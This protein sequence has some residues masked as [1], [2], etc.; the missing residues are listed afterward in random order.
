[1]YQS[2]DIWSFYWPMATTSYK[3]QNVRDITERERCI[4]RQRCGHMMATTPDHD[5]G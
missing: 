3:I 4:E 2:S 5:L 1:M